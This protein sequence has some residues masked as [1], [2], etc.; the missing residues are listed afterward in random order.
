M[1]VR[2]KCILIIL[3]TPGDQIRAAWGAACDEDILKRRAVRVFPPSISV[4]G[5]RSDSISRGKIRQHAARRLREPS[6][7]RGV[8]L[9]Y[10]EPLIL[11]PVCPHI[12]ACRG[13]KRG[14]ERPQNLAPPVC[15]SDA[16]F[17]WPPFRGRPA[18]QLRYPFVPG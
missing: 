4:L 12:R 9:R 15:F 5:A 14:T 17:G 11:L 16:R 1:M 10:T 6:A 7:R 2:V 18:I 3:K 8:P 13:R